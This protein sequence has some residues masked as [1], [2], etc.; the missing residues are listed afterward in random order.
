MVWAQPILWAKSERIPRSRAA[1][2]AARRCAELPSGFRHE[3]LSVQIAEQCR[4]AEVQRA[5]V[6]TRKRAGFSQRGTLLT[7]SYRR[8]KKTDEPRPSIRN[9]AG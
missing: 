9:E 3:M 5:L 2:E 8:G 1:R 7:N 4:R 6:D